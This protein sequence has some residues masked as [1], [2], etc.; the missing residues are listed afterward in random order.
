MNIRRHIKYLF[1]LPVILFA[2][3]ADDTF[4]VPDYGREG[5][6]ATISLKIEV[7]DMGKMQSRDAMTDEETSQVN[8][9]WIGIYNANTGERTFSNFYT[10]N[11]KDKHDKDDN[12]WVDPKPGVHEIDNIN[13]KSGKSYI[14]AVANAK[15]NF[16]RTSTGGKD[17][18]RLD[19]LLQQ[20]DTW[21]KYKD[22]SA[23]LTM[24]GNVDRYTADF[25]MSGIYYDNK[26]STVTDPSDD[27]A[28]VTANE[29]AV[30]I[31][32]KSWD[33][34]G[35]IHL[36][37]L[38][39]YVKF[40]I[41]AEKS[42]HPDLTVEPQ[43]WQ[44]VNVP[45]ISYLHEQR[46]NSCDADDY[47]NA[48]VSPSE[49]RKDFKKEGNG[50]SFGF[51]QM[52]NK[53]TGRETVNVYEDRE[54]EY[55]ENNGLNSKVYVSLCPSVNETANNSASFVEI[56]AKVSYNIAG[57][58]RI[59]YTKYTI[60]LGYCE[61]TDEATKSRDFRH[62]RN[63]KYT[64]NVRIKDVDKIIVEA[65]KDGELQPGAEG[66]VTDM[67][68]EQVD[69]DCHYIIYNIRLTKEDRDKEKFQWR[70]RCPYGN[71][72]IDLYSGSMTDEQKNN[73][74]NMKNSL[75]Y[76]WVR[77]YPTTNE[78][79]PAKY[80]GDNTAWY[81]EDLRDTEGHPH[82][83]NGEW[84]TVFIDENTYAY[85]ESMKKL[86]VNDWVRSDWH[87]YVN[88]PDRKV[89]IGVDYIDISHDT[90][91]THMKAKYLIAQ[92]SIQTYFSGEADK[93]VGIE[94]TNETLGKN[95]GWIWNSNKNDLSKHN[96]RYN[97]W[98][99]LTDNG[100][101][102]DNVITANS[103]L[104]IE[105]VN[106]QGRVINQHK[107]FVPELPSMWKNPM[108]THPR[109]NDNK[110][111]EIISACMSR[112]R[113]NNGDGKITE[114]EVRW[115]VPT[116][117]VYLQMVMGADALS[118][119]L[120]EYGNVPTLIYPSDLS[121]VGNVR[122]NQFFTRFHYAGSD[123]NYIFAEEGVSTGGIDQYDKSYNELKNN[124]PQSRYG[125]WEIRC[126]RN[127][128]TNIKSTPQRETEIS[129]VYSIDKTTRTITVAGLVTS[130][131]RAPTGSHLLEHTIEKTSNNLSP[132][133]EYA[134]EDCM[135]GR[136]IW[137]S[138]DV[139]I[140]ADGNCTMGNKYANW[141][142]SIESNSV[143]K[144]YSQNGDN[145]GWRVPNQKEL[146]VM[147][148]LGIFDNQ[149][150]NIKWFSATR[151]YYTVNKENMQRIMGVK[152]NMSTA[153]TAAYNHVRCVRDVIK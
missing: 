51:Y 115:Y 141:L 48:E 140:D 111:Y 7:P 79:T 73:L 22:I 126:V 72:V 151:E 67:V 106:Q 70:V 14:V 82:P 3:C 121:A 78:N 135:S 120:M 124:V 18:V 13:T 62:R 118:T 128:G 41:I 58:T 68:R 35:F 75:F 150:D 76:T 134:V 46:T 45:T 138:P 102:W 36:R 16:G 117:S 37:R 84:Y 142:K 29:E 23:S 116:N 95:L 139:V 30:F 2:G 130:G 114:D 113:D 9:L 74:L 100:K 80:P 40:N 91:S 53:H 107:E 133:F 85:D 98:K 88:K 112:N 57:G 38:H 21:D 110:I 94:H 129:D 34:P 104:N 31:P 42:A 103:F 20:A 71:D 4:D 56:N 109:P 97:V 92:K 32:E 147:M 55:K 119:P 52:E 144:N 146:T 145:Q 59:A 105:S 60:H 27:D 19:L 11:Y 153:G 83:Y 99:Y 28:W 96:G 39:S 33:A 69:V 26:Q 136:N 77:I 25:P 90:E 125:Y 6:P 86:G 123:M 49:I 5:E 66:D 148:E 24:E 152:K 47:R 10:L 101:L 63:T 65:K 64:Y 17:L 127:L 143:C 61:G 89:W 87:K 12:W 8:D 81:L 50:F 44:V 43:S 132:A 122:K 15:T 137:Y 54:K 93:I 149:P 131:M 1:A 108:Y